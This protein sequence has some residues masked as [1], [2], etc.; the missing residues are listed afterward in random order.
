MAKTE[1]EDIQVNP[2]D[3]DV[4]ATVVSDLLHLSSMLS[5]PEGKVL[6]IASEVSLEYDIGMSDLTGVLCAVANAGL[7]KTE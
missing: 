7:L 4:V 6:H 1:T 5:I 2:V 3:P